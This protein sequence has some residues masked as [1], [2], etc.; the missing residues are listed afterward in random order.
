MVS[1]NQYGSGL[2]VSFPAS[3]EY[4][5][6]KWQRVRL[7]SGQ[8]RDE[9]PERVFE[10]LLE[11]KWI[12]PSETVSDDLLLDLDRPPTLCQLEL[13]LVWALSGDHSG[14]YNSKDVVAFARL[15]VPPD[16][17]LVGTVDSSK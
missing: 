11:H 9:D 14:E 15:I 2:Q 1:L 6:F 12:E 8:P 4:N 3:V 17:S 5:E 16:A 7:S 10:V 13:T